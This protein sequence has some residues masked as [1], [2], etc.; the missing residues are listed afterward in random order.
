LDGNS[1]PHIRVVE[2]GILDSGGINCKVHGVLVRGSASR[3]VDNRI[4]H[5]TLQ[6][7][8]LCPSHARAAMRGLEFMAVLQSHALFASSASLMKPSVYESV[9]PYSDKDNSHKQTTCVKIAGADRYEIHFDPQCHT[10]ADVDTLIFSVKG[11]PMRNGIFH[12]HNAK[13]GW[14]PLVIPAEEFE[15]KFVAESGA[16]QWGYKFTV[17]PMKD[18]DFSSFG[19]SLQDSLAVAICQLCI[20]DH[21]VLGLPFTSTADGTIAE[22][23]LMPILQGALLRCMHYEHIRSAAERAFALSFNPISTL[24]FASSAGPQAAAGKHQFI[25]LSAPNIFANC[26]VLFFLF[27]RFHAHRT[28]RTKCHQEISRQQGPCHGLPELAA[29]CCRPSVPYFLMD[30]R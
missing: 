5:A 2:I 21:G 3:L 24:S 11:E 25:A 27:Y 9:H 23:S 4:V 29:S 13:D 20:D 14:A 6:S 18:S 7:L 12:G 8:T 30:T 17:N 10:E 26:D 19:D 15:F 1:D 22:S 16:S 28:S